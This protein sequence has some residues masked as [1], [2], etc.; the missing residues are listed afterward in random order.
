MLPIVN[1]IHLGTTNSTLLF[2]GL[3]VGGHLLFLMQLLER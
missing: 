1:M 3:H 2:V